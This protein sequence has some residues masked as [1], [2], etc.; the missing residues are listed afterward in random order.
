MSRRDSEKPSDDDMVEELA[1]KL[2]T[3]PAPTQMSTTPA[4]DSVNGT[5]YID[6]DAEET[7][8]T[9]IVSPATPSA[10]STKFR[11]GL[12]SR[13]LSSSQRRRRFTELDNDGEEIQT[14][15][16][17]SKFS[18]V[19]STEPR[20]SLLARLHEVHRQSTNNQSSRGPRTTI[21]SRATHTSTVI[22]IQQD[23]IGRSRYGTSMDTAIVLDDD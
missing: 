17:K 15:T 11:P 7:V 12:N 3:T 5:I 10:R 4:L 2:R 9:T 21:I 6:V 20:G 23:T 18:E 14:P 13:T 1:R 22:S 8:D 16:K 19:A